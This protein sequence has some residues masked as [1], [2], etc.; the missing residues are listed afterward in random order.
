[1]KVNT[2]LGVAGIIVLALLVITLTP[3]LLVWAINALF[4]TG[5]PYTAKTWAAA[6]ILGGAVRAGTK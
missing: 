2:G 1:M 4:G 3:W 6:L 5:I